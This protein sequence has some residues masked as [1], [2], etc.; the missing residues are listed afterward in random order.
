MSRGLA[1]FV[2]MLSGVLLLAAPAQSH[3]LRPAIATVSFDAP[4]RLQL[5]LS[6]NLE[7]LIAEI[8]PG[9]DDTSESANAAGY[10]RLRAL[11]PED[12]RA[13]LDRFAPRLLAGIEISLDGSRV[14]LSLAE[15][16][17]PQTGDT[18]LA[19]ISDLRFAANV[20][21]GA[22]NLLWRFDPAFGDSVIRLA[23]GCLLYTSDAADDFAVV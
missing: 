15:A 11:A 6:A 19:R 14:P 9:H 22:E 23:R 18:D 2:L 4:G 3:E 10:D 1:V 21:A 16:D 8:G 7:A 20:S 17:I 12:L 5:H 13:E